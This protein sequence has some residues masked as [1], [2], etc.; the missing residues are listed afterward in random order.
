MKI[1]KLSVLGFKSFMDRIEITFPSGISGIVGPN[2]CGKSNVVD[3]IRWCMGE[4]SPKQ[5]R[6]RKMEDIIFGGAKDQKPLGMA[7]V[8]LT[9]ENGDGSFPATYKEYSELSITRRL[10]RSGESEY[11]INN[12]PCRLKDIHEIF[13]DTGLGN[14]AYSIIG[15]GK[16]GAIIEQRPEETREMLEE[17]AGITKY[18]KKAEA[19]QRKIE[20]TEANL[21]RVQDILSEVETQMRSLKRQAGKAKRYKAICEEIRNLELIL[22]SNTYDQLKAEAGN[23]QKSTEE[24]EQEELAQSTRLANIQAEV[25]TM[26]ME[27]E[28]KDHDLS[29][30]RDKYLHLRER[31][32]KKEAGIE[33]LDREVKLQEELKGRLKGEKEEIGRRIVRLKEEKV[34]LEQE[35]VKMKENYQA[36]AS[37][38]SLQEDRLKNRKDSLTFVKE[39]YE[40]AREILNAGTNKEIGLNHESEYLK[41]LLHQVTDS[42]SRLEKELHDVKQRTETVLGASERKNQTRE[43]TREKLNAL[44]AGIEQQQQI[45]AEL[46]RIK[47]RVENERKTAEMDLNM[48]RSR[49]ASL[50]GLTDNF[51][52]YQKAVRTIMKAEDLIPKQKGHV[53]GLVADFIQVPSACEQAVESALADRLQYIIVENQEDGKQAVDYLKKRER[54]RGGFVP[55]KDLNGDME[56]PRQDMP[57]AYLSDLVTVPDTCKG[58]IHALLG[59]V[60][61]ADSLEEALRAWKQYRSVSGTG[62]GH[63]SFVTP[64]GDMV[65]AR[66]IIS[67]GKS[68]QHSGGL[69]ARKREM[70]ELKEHVASLQKNSE[71][72]KIRLEDIRNSVNEKKQEI[73]DLHR[74]KSDCQEQIN[75]LDNQLFRL[76]QELDQLDKLSKKI[77]Q[78]MERNAVEQAKNKEALIRIAAEL[79]Q[80]KTSREEGEAY[81]RQKEQE[82]KETEI[83]YER[84]RE[85]VSQ[86]KADYRIQEEE[87][88][89]KARESARIDEYVDDAHERIRKIEEE[90]DLS[91]RRC[92]EGARQKEEIREQLTGLYERLKKAEQEVQEA[93]QERNEFAGAIREKEHEAEEIRSEMG[94]LKE[95]I[96]RAKMEHSEIH[97]KMNN[98]VDMARQKYNLELAEVYAQYLVEDFSGSEME[99]RIAHQKTLR[100]NLG[101]VNLVAIKEHEALSE[102]HEF[103]LKQKEDLIKSIDAL[104]TAIRKI[105]RTCLEK[106]SGVFQDV[107]AKLKEIFPILFNGG[108]AG[109][110]L[111]DESK[112]LE[113]G[114][115]VEVQPP[116]KKLGHMGLLS[117]G[118]KALVAMALLFAIYMIKPSPFCLLDEVDAPLDEANIDRFNN[119]LGEIK[120]LSQ[121]IMV[122]HSRRTMEVVDRLY[123]ITMETAGMSK[124]VSVDIH[125][126][127]NDVIADQQVDT[128]VLH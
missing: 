100:Q 108:T 46:E 17:A 85:E 105:N 116:G 32:H 29:T 60:V 33:S 39:E 35:S 11:R 34:L 36:M 58:L 74:A 16:I 124:V 114:V 84:L 112:P 123:G 63:L 31:V 104:R 98:L 18:R 68:G 88:R 109:L 75:G 50:Q 111:V 82:L 37:E 77:S 13:M 69:L 92:Q 91:R 48:A 49:L 4:Q 10:F 81:F 66:G 1:R 3:A 86:L 38:I 12:V 51:E 41:K 55:I 126:L 73:D 93:D 42:N 24:L 27:L 113:S 30:L 56:H 67:G 26:Q 90:I 6:G 44:V 121:I 97:Y 106:F 103:M 78:D 64:Q 21:Q 119:L 52:G 102:R 61:M 54:G 125:N 80:H 94:D 117:G 22:Y 96:N 128:A 76:S 23:K 122:T 57:Y 25:E 72:L 59:N 28:E 62:K 87:Q 101:E 71:D 15:Q 79:S 7:E 115:L 70:A 40:K 89:G 5:L 20:Q 127:K 120:R 43:A 8:S 9:F 118:E 99:E 19:S 83:E 47:E 95:T 107:D 53:L 110:R 14:S 45:Y 65:D 2:G